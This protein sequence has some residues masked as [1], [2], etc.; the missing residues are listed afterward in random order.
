M[1][2]MPTIP[3]KAAGIVATT[4]FGV[5]IY[6]G[7]FN[8]TLTQKTCYKFNPINKGWNQAIILFQDLSDI[9]LADAAVLPCVSQIVAFINKISKQYI[10]WATLFHI[11]F[12]R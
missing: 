12:Y 11:L 2:S 4:G 5:P 7:G 10:T 6:C 9:F 1:C 3:F 8:S